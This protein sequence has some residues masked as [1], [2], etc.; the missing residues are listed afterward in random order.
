MPSCPLAA[1]HLVIA[2]ARW[3]IEFSADTQKYKI[4][5]P[6]TL[7]FLLFPTK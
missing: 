5:L 1:F 7:T 3:P 4:H 6:V 2:K